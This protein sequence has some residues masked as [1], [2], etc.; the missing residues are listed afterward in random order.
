MLH[1]Y[2]AI[3]MENEI[4]PIQNLVMYI[5]NYAFNPLYLKMDTAF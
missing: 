5:D 1:Y 4:L 2:I 3:Y